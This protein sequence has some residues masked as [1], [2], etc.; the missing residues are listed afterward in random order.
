V[1]EEHP[2]S[3]PGKAGKLPSCKASPREIDNLNS[4]NIL[5]VIEQF[6]VNNLILCIFYHYCPKQPKPGTA[7]SIFMRV[8][9]KEYIIFKFVPLCCPKA[10][11]PMDIRGGSIFI[12]C[13]GQE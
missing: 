7:R 10:G 1:R 9:E 2:W 4:S 8:L 6:K 11:E 3:D 12:F 5:N 13:F